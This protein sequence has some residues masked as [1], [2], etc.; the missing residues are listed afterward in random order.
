M[1]AVVIDDIPPYTQGIASGGQ[2]VFGT[3]WTANYASDV[4]VYL[5]PNG[6]VAND[7]TQILSYPSQ[8]SVSFIGALRQVQ[9]TLVTPASLGDR[10]TITRMTP[11]DRLNLYTNTN[12][13]PSML[14]NDFG[15]LTLV[16][17]QAQLVNQSIAPRYNYSSII[18]PV[19]DTILPILT[20]NQT[21]VKNSNNTAFIALDVPSGGIAPADATY[22]T[23][24]N[25]TSVLPNSFRLLAGTNVSFTTGSNTLTISVSG[26]SIIHGSENDLAYYANDGT[27]LSPLSNANNG[28]LVTSSIGV[29]SI[30][31]TLPASLTIPN[32]K[33][34]QIDDTNGNISVIIHG[35]LTPVNYLDFF[36]SE[37]GFPVIIAA[38]GTDS[39]V[40]LRFQTKNNAAFEFLSTAYDGVFSFFTGDTYQHRT[41]WNFP[42]TAE[43]RNVT[44]PDADGTLAYVSDI[45]T[46]AALTRVDD[47]N[48]TL[49]LGGSPSTALLNAT[50][51]TLGWT[52]LLAGSRGGTGV[53]N[54]SNTATYAG[55][56]NFANSFTTSGNFAV[57]QTYTGATNVTFPTSGTLATT[58]QIPTGA[59]LTKTD[60][61][62]VTL[63]LGGSPSTALLNAASLT[64]GWTG[65]L[66]VSRG[67]TGLAAITAHNLIIGN[68]TSAAT[69][70][71]PSATSGVPLIS[72]GSSA[73]PAYGT[74]VV[75]GGGTG[76]TTTTAY[77]LIA[78]GTT[79]TGAFQ[80]AGTGT[81]G[82]LYVSGG[83]AALGT[84]T[85][86]SGTG[87][88]LRGD[89]GTWTPQVSPN[90][91]AFGSITYSIQFG[92]WT[93]VGNVIC[94]KIVV[95]LTAITIGTAA[96]AFAITGLPV[97]SGGNYFAPGSVIFA[98]VTFLGTSVA[99]NVPI[100]QTYITFYATGSGL[101]YYNLQV[102]D[103]TATS[104]IIA[105]G[106][107]FTS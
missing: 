39:L 78:G 77:G 15:I 6:D 65:Q 29:P 60:D 69:L 62:N 27:V 5:T 75:A 61:T 41:N 56:L 72:Q 24:G 96:G 10:V 102:T 66:G 84:W 91:G 103:L 85:D 95:V 37:T 17:Q 12:F 52:G 87:K 4:V 58:S 19:V 68:G 42:N 53:N 14:N 74:A 28:V 80:N 94:W 40:S 11:A 99:S 104:E 34:N 107:Y 18:T 73:D 33:I 88:I 86:S 22:I 32:P 92:E 46:G 13:T 43:T 100:G 82:Q 25:Q 76:I 49:T 63:T 36:N 54:G 83:N 64:L 7:Q 106:F 97:A 31:S 44:W 48:V 59:A 26:Q 70:L 16:D 38:N 45:P 3:N 2:T 90:T 50:S 101:N 71:A 79:A 21:W 89:T 51:L 23:N 20:A 47:T 1:T 98:N 9:V 55:N 8:Y 67:G 30:S 105:S 93:R 81:S 57:T 35:E